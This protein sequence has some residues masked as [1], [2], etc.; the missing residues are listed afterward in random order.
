MKDSRHALILLLALLL[1][2]FLL[3]LGFNG[4]RDFENAA[5]GTMTVSYQAKD[6]SGSPIHT[7]KQRTAEVESMRN[8][9]KGDS[10]IFFL[11][12]SQTHSINQKKKAD[13]IYPELISRSEKTHKILVNSLPN[14]N[15]QEFYTTLNWWNS[16][17]AIKRLVIPVFMDD[18]RE[19]G[20]RRDFMSGLTRERYSMPPSDAQLI[21]DW[22]NQLQGFLPKD[23]SDE[24]GSAES[25][26]PQDRVEKAINSWLSERSQTWRNRPNARGDIF[27]KLYQWRNKAFGIK[28]TSKRKMIPARMNRNLEALDLLIRFTSE[29]EIDV[30]LYIPPIRQDVEVPYDLG[31][32]Q[33][34]ISEIENLAANEKHVLF[35][36]W[37]GIVPANYWGVKASTNGSDEPELDFM[38]FQFAG[39]EI[40]ADSILNVLSR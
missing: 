17:I 5:L 20:L 16:S 1:A 25:E 35:K 29:N 34:F 38:H 19:D 4:D 21:A 30:L 22:N 26:T 13:V 9:A 31:E 14:A 36:N 12:N 18:L 27:M 33:S 24:N 39:H 40:L 8:Y 11:G 10:V 37:E 7:I 15:L 6:S 3:R 23:T 28:A 32:Y 2:I